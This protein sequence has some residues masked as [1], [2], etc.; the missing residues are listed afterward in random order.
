MNPLS[1]GPNPSGATN[2]YLNVIMFE[3][4]NDRFTFRRVLYYPYV[5]MI[6]HTVIQ[7]YITVKYNKYS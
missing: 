3:C 7:F 6:I 2:K 4:K 5:H 1:L